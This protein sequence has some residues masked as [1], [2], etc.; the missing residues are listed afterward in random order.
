MH[1]TRKVHLC[2]RRQTYVAEATVTLPGARAT[3][4]ES[5]GLLSSDVILIIVTAALPYHCN[6]T[7]TASYDWCRFTQQS[8]ECPVFSVPPICMLNWQ[9]NLVVNAVCKNPCMVTG[10]PQRLKDLYG[11]LSTA[12]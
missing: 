3:L 6:A 7:M 8:Q 2:S 4:S 5:T 11:M 9:H 10:V 12:P 1:A